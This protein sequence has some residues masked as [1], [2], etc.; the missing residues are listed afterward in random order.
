VVSS[1]MNT[2]LKVDARLTKKSR[3]FFY[4]SWVAL[5]KAM[6]HL[7]P[8]AIFPTNQSPAQDAFR[9]KSTRREPQSAHR[10]SR[11]MLLSNTV[12]SMATN[13]RDVVSPNGIDYLIKTIE[14]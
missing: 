3:K 9:W 10:A 12:S 6:M 1:M 5:C 14:L 7:P 13:R 4:P 8:P 11:K 2:V